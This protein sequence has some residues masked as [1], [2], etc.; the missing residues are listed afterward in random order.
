[1]EVDKPIRKIQPP[2]RMIEKEYDFRIMIEEVAH[3]LYDYMNPKEFRTDKKEFLMVT[4]DYLDYYI[5]NYTN[6]TSFMT[7]YKKCV[8]T[9]YMAY[10]FGHELTKKAE[11]LTNEEIYDAVKYAL[12]TKAPK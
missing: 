3:K 4:Y 7:H 12:K 11:Q 8:I 9:G 2:K 10:V 1:L 6:E 5:R